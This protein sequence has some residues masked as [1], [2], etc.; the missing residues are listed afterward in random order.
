MNAE[1]A[2]SHLQRA[3]ASSE[4]ACRGD[5]RFIGDGRGG[6]QTADLVTICTDCP[7][8]PQCQDYAVSLGF[9]IAGFWA[10]RWRGKYLTEAE[11][12]AV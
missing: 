6:A 12:L 2:W 4:P 11:D 7:I 1:T 10:G 3:L 9:R 8:R 5:D